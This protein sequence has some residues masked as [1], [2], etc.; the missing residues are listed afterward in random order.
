[1]KF[2]FITSLL[3]LCGSLGTFA[4]DKLQ[5][6]KTIDE[7]QKQFTSDAGKVRLIALLSPT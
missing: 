1:M 5:D 3:L 7:L 4:Q 2:V 6:L